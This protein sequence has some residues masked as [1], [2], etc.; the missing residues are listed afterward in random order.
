MGRPRLPDPI[1]F[2]EACKKTLKRKMFQSAI[3]DRTA[4][5]KRRFCD[6]KCM[7]VWMEGRIKVLTPKNSRRQSAKTVQAACE[8]C[9]HIG[10]LHVHHVDE[11]PLNNATTNLKTLCNSCHRRSHSPNYTG[12]P[13]RKKPCSLCSKPL[14][15]RGLCNTHLTRFRK[16]GD[17]LL[18]K[19]GNASGMRIVR[20]DG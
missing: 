7:A 9:S 10:R 2:C 8:Y 12:I 18:V 16:H 20:L 17:P 4:F 14:A 11:N 15:R 19:R 6:Q 13:P 1:K 5:K 3:E